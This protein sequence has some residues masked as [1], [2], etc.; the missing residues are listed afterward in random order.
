MFEEGEIE[1][2]PGSISMV[3]IG[4]GAGPGQVTNSMFQPIFLSLFKIRFL[5]LLGQIDEEIIKFFM[6]PSFHNLNTI[7]VITNEPKHHKQH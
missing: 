5:W 7:L 4:P 1:A 2:D 6:F 3:L